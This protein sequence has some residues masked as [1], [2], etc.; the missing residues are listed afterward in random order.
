MGKTRTEGSNFEVDSNQ[1]CYIAPY[2]DLTNRTYGLPSVMTADEYLAQLENTAAG[3]NTIKSIRV[4]SFNDIKILKVMEY[5]NGVI[6]T[7]QMT[8]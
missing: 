6:L 7:E 5:T 8:R 3:D 1:N 4:D 2:E